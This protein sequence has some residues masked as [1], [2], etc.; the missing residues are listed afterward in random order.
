MKT[1]K[2]K[3]PRPKRR[4]GVFPTRKEVDKSKVIPRKEKHKEKD[5]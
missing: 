2:G 4:A 3:V 1:I 5:E